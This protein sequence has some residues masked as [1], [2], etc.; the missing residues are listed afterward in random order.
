M[1][2]FGYVA[3]AAAYGD[4]ECEAWR[5]R[6][7]AYL[8]ANRDYA[9]GRLRAMRISCDV[10]DVDGRDRERERESPPSTWPR[11][12]CHV[13]CNVNEFGT[14]ESELR[15]ERC[16]LHDTRDSPEMWERISAAGEPTGH[17]A[18]RHS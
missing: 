17:R 18:R 10:P 13:A 7:V 16:S 11:S 1:S 2:V 5:A 8:H 15:G 6:L 14:K 9:A 3:E 12:C 4:D